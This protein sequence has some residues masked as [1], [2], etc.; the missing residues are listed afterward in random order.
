MDIVPYRKRRKSVSMEMNANTPGPAFLC[1]D[2]GI[3]AFECKHEKVKMWPPSR[4]PI[5][6]RLIECKKP[7][8]NTA[9]CISC[10]EARLLTREAL[11]EERHMSNAKHRCFMQGRNSVI[12]CPGDTRDQ[13]VLVTLDYHMDVYPAN[14]LQ[15]L[16]A[17]DFYTF[18]CVA[19]WCMAIT[20]FMFP[21]LGLTTWI[22]SVHNAI[23]ALMLLLYLTAPKGMDSKEED[24]WTIFALS[25][26]AQVFATVVATYYE[27]QYSL[28]FLW[29]S[30][31]ICHV[32]LNDR[33]YWYEHRSPTAERLSLRNIDL[34][35]TDIHT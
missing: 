29:I 34:Q 3:H 14:L 20:L 35:I 19:Q 33:L 8:C 22:F 32:V 10:T 31:P 5:Q 7:G 1:Y 23:F 18:A 12:Y 16:W 30:T 21:S 4:K 17:R 27:V 24:I 15:R 26:F 6:Q 13:H 11:M 28:W 9:I 25:R 2:C